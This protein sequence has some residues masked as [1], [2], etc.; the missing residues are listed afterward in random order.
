MYDSQG[1]LSGVVRASVDITERKRAEE[2]LE[3]RVIARTR[4]LT[5]VNKVLSKEMVER[6]R[7]QQ[8]LATQYA[9]T[10][11][12]AAS[13]T[14]AVAIPHLLQAIGE[15]M[16]WEWGAL[17][18]IDRDAGVLRC[19]RIWHAPYLEVAEFDTISRQTAGMPGKSLKGYVWQNAEPAWMADAMQDPNIMRAPIAARVGLRGAIAFPILLLGETIAVME[20]FSHT[21]R[22]VAPH[23]T[24]VW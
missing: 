18:D 14:L 20:F 2:K 7:A 16:E 15:S 21:V 11:V 22:Q 9:I 23:Q 10:R 1:V 3:R 8:R 19:H 13:D 12:L 4:Q 24:V 5:A 6:Q 17:W